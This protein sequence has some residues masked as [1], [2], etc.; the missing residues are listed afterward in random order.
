MYS[1]MTLACSRRSN[2]PSRERV[3]DYETKLDSDII[4]FLILFSMV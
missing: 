2:E 1:I 4:G 3:T